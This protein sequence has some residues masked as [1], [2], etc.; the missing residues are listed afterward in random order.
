MDGKDVGDVQHRKPHVIRAPARMTWGTTR[1]A[2]TTSK[3]SHKDD[4]ER[5][6][7]LRG[8][9]S[10]A[11]SYPTSPRK[12]GDVG[13]PFVGRLRRP[14]PLPSSSRV[15]PLARNSQNFSSRSTQFPNFFFFL[16]LLGYS[17]VIHRHPFNVSAR[18][19]FSVSLTAKKT[20]GLSTQIAQ[21]DL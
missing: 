15:V 14:P 5:V 6:R 8:R 1:P 7:P 20:L 10:C 16:A 19:D 2:P 9:F 4:A 11:V 12:L 3:T 18:Y 17:H 21:V 13:F